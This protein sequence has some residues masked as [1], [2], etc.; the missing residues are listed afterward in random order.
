MGFVMVAWFDDLG[1][2]E[3]ALCV[4]AAALLIRDDLLAGFR[5]VAIQIRSRW[6]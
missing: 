3:I 4:F 1:S 2:I 5:F 6:G